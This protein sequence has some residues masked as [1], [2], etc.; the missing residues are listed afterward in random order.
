M[1]NA[2][3]GED[4]AWWYQLEQGIT[5]NTPGL[6]VPSAAMRRLTPEDLAPISSGRTDKRIRD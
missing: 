3:L 6:W 4:G 2:K 5:I 1:V